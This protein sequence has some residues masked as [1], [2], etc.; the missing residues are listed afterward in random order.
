M[1]FQCQIGAWVRKQK[2]WIGH[3]KWVSGQFVASFFFFF[4]SSDQSCCCENIWRPFSITERPE[5]PSANYTKTSS[6]SL[7]SFFHIILKN[8]ISKLSPWPAIHQHF[9]HPLHPISVPFHLN[10]PH[11]VC[12]SHAHKY[13]AGPAPIQNNYRR[14][15]SSTHPK[16]NT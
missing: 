8:S 10:P 11:L 5:I 2:S 6:T 1:S 3:T 9:R 16:E 7:S 14:H 12:T 15:I 13:P 4:G